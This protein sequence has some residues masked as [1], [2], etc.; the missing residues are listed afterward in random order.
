MIA[1]P[2]KFLIDNCISGILCLQSAS[3]YNG[4]SVFPSVPLMVYSECDIKIETQFLYIYPVEKFDYRYTIKIRDSLYV[5]NPARTVIDLILQDGEEQFIFESL[6][7][8]LNEYSVQELYEV[9]DV[10][11]ARALLDL[12][13]SEMD[14]FF[15]D[16][17]E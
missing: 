5:T 3:W 9:A 17:R 15:N 2:S 4:L 12:K 16:F 1:D 14:D 6:E 8:Y 10:Y 13:I 7:D 11:N